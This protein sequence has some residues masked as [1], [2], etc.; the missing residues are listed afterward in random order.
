MKEPESNN[1]RIRWYPTICTTLC[2][3]NRLVAGGRE[4]IKSLGMAHPMFGYFIVL[5]I[6][7]CLTPTVSLRGLS[8]AVEALH[9]SMPT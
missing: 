2:E 3:T 8:G 6:A 5:Q 9:W 4:M 1:L 7:K